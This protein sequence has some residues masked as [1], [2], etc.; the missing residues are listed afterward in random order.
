MDHNCDKN[1][2]KCNDLRQ[3]IRKNIQAENWS[4]KIDY[5]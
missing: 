4:H 3:Q 2:V 1:G 5:R